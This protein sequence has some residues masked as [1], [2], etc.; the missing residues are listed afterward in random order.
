MTK[1][2]ILFLILK[3][4]Y[5]PKSLQGPE[6]TEM[7]KWKESRVVPTELQNLLKGEPVAWFLAMQ[8]CG[9]R[10]HESLTFFL[11]KLPISV[12]YM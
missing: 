2:L 11:V 4:G 8:K 12:F 10:V 1:L 9:P 5:K 7:S 6:V 3:M